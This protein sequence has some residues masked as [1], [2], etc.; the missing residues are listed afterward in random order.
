MKKI[1]IIFL[2]MIYSIGTV[3]C[4]NKNVL[5]DIEVANTEIEKSTL[6]KEEKNWSKQ[7][8][9]DMFYNMTNG[10]IGIEYLDCVLIPDYASER[11][12]AVLFENTQDGTTEVAFFDVNGYAQQCGI[13]AKAAETPELT[14]IGDGTVTFKLEMDEDI[15][16]NCTVSISVEGGNTKFVITEDSGESNEQISE[17]YTKGVVEC[18]REEQPELY[19]AIQKLLEKRANLQY[20]LGSPDIDLYS[21]DTI[22]RE[23]G[24]VYYPLKDETLTKSDLENQL[25][26]I[27]DYDYSN[28]LLEY[29]FDTA[30]YY[31]EQDGRLYGQD[32]AAVITTL[33]DDWTILKE[34]NY[35]YYLQGYEDVD[36][37]SMLILKIVRSANDSTFRI[38][39]ELE[40]NYEEDT[41]E[42]KWTREEIQKEYK[43]FEL[44]KK[45]YMDPEELT[46]AIWE[47]I[48]S[49]RFSP[50]S[51]TKTYEKEEWERMMTEKYGEEWITW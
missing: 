38:F 44:A 47:G 40:I 37:K 9:A 16:Y 36:V 25:L 12:G 1:S 22:E 26:E 27:Y 43:V 17:N 11:I 24:R 3:A 39:D 15:I 42:N 21:D 23:D 31:M 45:Y 5:Q 32:L 49:D 30:K 46:D 2:M 20:M 28:Q 41:L 8:I 13:Y 19:G 7:D 35:L 6:Q 29:Y 18:S 50:F 14:Y 10:E 4:G 48:H 33:K 51:N 34:N